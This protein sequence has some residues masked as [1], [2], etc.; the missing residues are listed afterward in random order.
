M[1]TLSLRRLWTIYFFTSAIFLH[2]ARA[3][4]IALKAENGTLVVPVLINGKITLDFTLD[5]GAADV[6]IPLDVF[7]TLQRTDTIS[8]SD[9]LQPGTYELADGSV[10][11]QQR[12]RVRSLKV[13]SVELRDV[14]GSVAPVRGSLLLGQS[15]LSRLRSWSVDNLRREFLINEGPP[16]VTATASLNHETP[17]NHE[18]PSSQVADHRSFDDEACGRAQKLCREG[19]GW[20]CKQYR[21][22][23]KTVNRVCPGVSDETR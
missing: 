18:A 7:L 21:E 3:E 9:L 10:H 19:S 6:S 11:R 14:V 22:D 20:L 23:F 2:C 16:Q 5:S 4:T 17:V 12:F 1:T 8:E 15:F 13:G